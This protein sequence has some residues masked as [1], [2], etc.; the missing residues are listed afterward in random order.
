MTMRRVVV[1]QSMY[2]PW[3]GLLEQV[4]LA[5]VFIHYDD[6]QFTRN[7][8]FGRV[9]V[10]IPGGTTW[11][12]VPLSDFRRGQTID[13]VRVKPVEEW[14]ERHLSLLEE[15]LRHAPFAED[16]FDLFRTVV[17]GKHDTIGELARAS[18]MA[19]SR[20]FGLEDGTRFVDSRDLGVGGSSSQRLLG[21][22]KAVGGTD[23]ITGHGAR[24]YLDHGIFEAEGISVSYMDYQRT[25]YPQS[26]GA[27]T[28]YVTGLDLVA[29][30]GRGGLSNIA[31]Q[32]LNW[33]DFLHGPS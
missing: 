26:H 2:F 9:Q 28:P 8:F 32:T 7:S 4:R 24:N 16:A 10:K 15:S 33:K 29:H 12:S 3:V 21:L 22:V 11:M 30:C 20:Y 13:E 19:L 25:P 18:M 27:F 6:V 23:Y 17:A 5:D 31:S 14:A 1:S